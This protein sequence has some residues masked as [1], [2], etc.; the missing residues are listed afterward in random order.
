MN[1]IFFGIAIILF[2]VLAF[3][4]TLYVA[5]DLLRVAEEWVRLLPPD[6]LSHALDLLD[7]T[8]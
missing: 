5:S 3:V 8:E 7:D 2:G 1:F 4:G 6:E